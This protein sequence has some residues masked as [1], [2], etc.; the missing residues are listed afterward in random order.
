MTLK[1][2]L[3]GARGAFAL[4]VAFEV[5]ADGVTALVGRSGSGKTSVL[6]AVAGLDRHRGTVSFNG[7]VWQDA[8]SFVPPERR[9]VGFVPQGIGLLPHL[10]VAANLAYAAKRAPAGPFG[11]AD[12][13]ARTGIGA[14]L[15]RRPIT[16]SG[17]EAQR[18]SLAR[19][20]L[21]QPR[22]LLLD[23][24][25]SGVDTEGRA[26]LLAALEMLLRGLGVPV[27]MVTHDLAE[28]ERLADR[29][30]QMS[31]GRVVA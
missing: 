18:A 30:V 9:H 11:R 10:S 27:V 20:L 7:A 13:V 5:P 16:L 15:N 22:L 23:E 3:Q 26:E 31:L 25:L 12:V 4:D 24:P 19:A 17:G 1:V 8:R 6:R 2:A 21:G 29:T 14:L 28:A